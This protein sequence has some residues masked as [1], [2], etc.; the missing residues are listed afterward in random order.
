M[1]LPFLSG[2][3]S[4]TLAVQH[5]AAGDVAIAQAQ[6]QAAVGVAQWNAAAASAVANAES[7]RAI[8]VASIWAGN[9]QLLII[10]AFV[11][12]AFWFGYRLLALYYRNRAAI[13]APLPEVRV[14]PP[15]PMQVEAMRQRAW[16]LGGELKQNRAGEWFV[17]VGNRPVKQ[18]TVRE[19]G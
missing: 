2:C 18:L 6:A 12:V 9:V 11:V 15:N 10:L 5:R 13:P 14:L 1:A 17:L 4:L 19:R 16:E 3:D 7:N 8:A